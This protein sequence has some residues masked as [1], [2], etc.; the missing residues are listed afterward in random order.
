MQGDSPSREASFKTENVSTPDEKKRSPCLVT[1]AARFPVSTGATSAG[2]AFC[3]TRD[4]GK[5]RTISRFHKIHG[6]GLDLVQK[7]FV[8]EIGDPVVVHDFVVIFRLIQ[9]HAQRGPGSAA[10]R[11]EDPDDFL[12]VLVLEKILDH[13]IRFACHLKHFSLLVS[14]RTS[15]TTP[16]KYAFQKNVSTA[17]QKK[18]ARCRSGLLSDPL[19]VPGSSNQ[20]DGMG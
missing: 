2:V 13:L 15:L 3:E 20:I 14:F 8:Y 11:Q 7:L 6:D 17:L 9:S 18:M 4:N 1:R 19:P 12:V 10:L 16:L 5:S